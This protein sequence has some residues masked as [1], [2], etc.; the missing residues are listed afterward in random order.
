[1]T[2]ARGRT[3]GGGLLRRLA[4]DASGATAIEFALVAP[5]LLALLFGSLE[6][7]RYIWFAAAL[8][9]AVGK[10][11]RCAEVIGGACATPQGLAEEVKG[12]LA[13]LAVLAPVGE[14]AL[15]TRAAACGTEIRVGLTYPSLVPGLGPVLPALNASACIG[16]GG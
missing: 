6:T 1:V 12:S 10:A 15:V 9:H 8:D 13:G 4:A 14:S 11:A 7:G 5:L 2:K 3:R 16:Q